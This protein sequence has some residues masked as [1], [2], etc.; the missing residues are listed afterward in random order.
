M[1]VTAKINI[2][3]GGFMKNVT[4]FFATIVVCVFFGFVA[5]AI[6]QNNTG[7][8]NTQRA[9]DDDDG[10]DDWGLLGLLGLGGLAGL[11]RKDDKRTVHSRSDN[12]N[13]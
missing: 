9:V 6:A 3:E 4:K 1:I 10:F 8:Q 2:N 5:P 7:N 11:N 12:P 13:K